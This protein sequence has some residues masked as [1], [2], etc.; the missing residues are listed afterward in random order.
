MT[1]G[2]TM[3]HE[4]RFTPEDQASSPYRLLPFAVP[5]NTK[6]VEV[7]YGYNREDG[8]I[9]DLGLFDPRGSDFLAAEGFRGWSGSARDHVVVTERWATPGYLAGP[10]IPGTWQVLLGLYRVASLGCSYRVEML[11]SPEEGDV[12]V[13]QASSLSR[14]GKMPAIPKPLRTRGS[15]FAPRRGPGWFKGDLQSH[16]HHSDAHP[17]VGELAAAARRRD[18]DFLAVTD[19]NTVSHH[20]H[21]MAQSSPDLLLIP[22]EEVTTYHGH[23]N[24]WGP[25]PWLDFRCSS[26]KEMAQVVAEAHQGGRLL[27]VNHPKPNGPEWN[28]GLELPFDCV[29]AWQGPWPWGNDYSLAFWENLLRRGRRV[30]AVG[31]SDSHPFPLASGRLFDWLGYP[32]TWVYAEALTA[33]GVLAGIKAG[34]VSISTCPTAARAFLTLRGGGHTALQ[35]DAV[36]LVRG[37]L[38]VRVIGGEGYWLRLLTRHGEVAR[39]HIPSPDWIYRYELELALHGYVRAEVRIPDS[40][41]TIPVERLPMVAMTNPIWHSGF[42]RP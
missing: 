1:A 19:H 18:L 32:T 11:R 2:M 30:V 23:A 36:E 4:G 40:R 17:S 42:L 8:N 34:H 41:G 12:P 26:D 31:G 29:E 10:I 16:T 6:R 14:A 38:E 20:A 35:G 13:G 39:E 21:L 24:V 33:E 5:N 15:E 37:E 7:R 28:F 27:S 9:L 25:G 22:S 3:V